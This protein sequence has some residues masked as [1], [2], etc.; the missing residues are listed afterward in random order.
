MVC[1]QLQTRARAAIAKEAVATDAAAGQRCNY[2]ELPLL[3]AMFF[4]SR[5]EAV[6]QVA[7]FV[8]RVKRLPWRVGIQQQK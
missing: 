6:C 7:R 5:R 1:T 3:S 4:S 8:L 2:C